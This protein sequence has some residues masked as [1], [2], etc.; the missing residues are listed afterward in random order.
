MTYCWQCSLL[1]AYRDTSDSEPDDDQEVTRFFRGDYGPPIESASFVA[2]DADK[3]ILGASMVCLHGG[4]PLDEAANPLLAHVVVRP[5]NQKR[6]VASAL[7]IASATALTAAGS[8]EFHLAVSEENQRANRL[9][10]HLGF[11]LWVD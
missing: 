8:F 9:Y 11:R 1:D 10:V 2:L 6:G 7:I 5:A 4:P 3:N